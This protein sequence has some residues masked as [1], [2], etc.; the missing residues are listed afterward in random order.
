VLGKKAKNTRAAKQKLQ[1]L[2]HNGQAL[3]KFQQL[4]KAQGGDL[5]RIPAARHK[6]EINSTGEG[7]IYS[8]DTKE[9]GLIAAWLG[10]GRQRKEDN[11]D[12]SAGII[13]QKKLGDPIS[14]GDSLATLYYNRAIPIN[15]IKKRF[16]KAVGIRTIKPKERPLVYKVL[17]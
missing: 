7:Y 13:L 1:R 15:E 17:G 6:V 9:I 2:I 3:N 4:V 8:M 14:L 12:P 11:I 5:A 10:A 16:I